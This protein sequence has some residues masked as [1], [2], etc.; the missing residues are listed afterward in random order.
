[1]Y[2]VFFAITGFPSLTKIEK[3]ISL[4]LLNASLIKKCLFHKEN[5]RLDY[6]KTQSTI[7]FKLEKVSIF[8]ML[9]TD[10]NFIVI[11]EFSL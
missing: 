3:K 11:S 4:I 10:R 2:F 9:V 8:F 6:K 1:M 7:F 5:L